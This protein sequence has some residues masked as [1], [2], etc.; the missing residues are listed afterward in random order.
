MVLT[1]EVA[2]ERSR[3]KLQVFGTTDRFRPE[4]LD[5][6]EIWWR[7]RYHRLKA[8][9]YLLRPRYSPEWVPPWT[10]S[11]ADLGRCEDAKRIRVCMFFPCLVGF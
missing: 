3:K 7:E 6:R 5:L 10:V 2:A 4:E 8:R 9:G 11:G 1:D